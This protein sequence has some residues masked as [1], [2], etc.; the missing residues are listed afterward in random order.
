MECRVAGKPAASQGRTAPP[1][2]DL[3]P[4]P[5]PDEPA[6]WPTVAREAASSG[7]ERLFVY[8]FALIHR[9]WEEAEGRFLALAT[10]LDGWA[11]AAYRRGEDLR[12][13]LGVGKSRLVAKTVR[14]ELGAPVRG[15]SETTLPI[16]WEATGAPGLFPRMEADLVIAAVGPELTHLGLRG[17]YRPPLGAVGRLVD[18]A[19]L[20]RVAESSIKGFVDRVARAL[21]GEGTEAEGGDPG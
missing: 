3:C 9:P 2:R 18:R 5:A 15:E 16:T 4:F 20:H 11:A 7:S 17:S 10:G 1:G 8:Y 12:A 21:E 6:H 14:V 13:R 19:L